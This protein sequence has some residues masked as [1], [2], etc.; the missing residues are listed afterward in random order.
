MRQRRQPTSPADATTS[1][2]SSSL[3]STSGT[4]WNYANPNY[5]VAARLVE[6][7]SGEELGHYL[8]RHIFQPAQMA[9]TTSTITDDQP[10]AGLAQGHVAAYGYRSRH[11]GSAA[12]P[13]ETAAS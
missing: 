4:S 7:L 1:L 3:A 8:R 9:A 11:P 2:R 13:P 6:V 10:V 12:T 5:Q